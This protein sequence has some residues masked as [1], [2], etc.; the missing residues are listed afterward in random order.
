[1]AKRVKKDHLKDVDFRTREVRQLE[2]LEDF[3]RWY[4]SLV[5]VK[6]PSDRLQGQLTMLSAVLWHLL[7]PSDYKK[8]VTRKMTKGDREAAKRILQEALDLAEDTS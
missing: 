6:R 5:V 4:E 2:A 1:M 3:K 8:L 7:P